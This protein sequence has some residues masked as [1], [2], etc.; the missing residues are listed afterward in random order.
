MK[1]LNLKE[2]NRDIEIRSD[3]EVRYAFVG[4]NKDSVLAK[5]NIFHK[6]PNKNSKIYVR[7]VL[8]DESRFDLETMLHIKKGARN[9]DTYFKAQVLLMS[10][11]ASARVVPSLEIEENE[12]KAGHAATITQVDKNQIYY[13]MSRGLTKEESENMLIESFL[14]F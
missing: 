5:L 7:V 3:Q 14:N 4:R 10:D 12:V 11:E 1:I 13:L 8:F 9:T 2:I 6:L